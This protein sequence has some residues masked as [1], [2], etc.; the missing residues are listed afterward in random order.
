LW[1]IYRYTPDPFLNLPSDW[2]LLQE[3]LGILEYFSKQNRCDNLWCK[4]RMV[5]DSRLLWWLAHFVEKWK[6]GYFSPAFISVAVAARITK[7]SVPFSSIVRYGLLHWNI[8]WGA[9]WSFIWSQ[10]SKKVKIYFSTK[11]NNK[12]RSRYMTELK[13]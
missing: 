3:P 10:K 9:T 8:I 4:L 2:S 6:K 1:G 12:E 11:I 5:T 13:H 7:L